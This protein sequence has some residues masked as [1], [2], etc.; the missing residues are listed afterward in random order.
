MRLEVQFATLFVVCLGL[1][2]L[3]AGGL[4]YRVESDHARHELEA[5]AELVLETATA[6][7]GY[8]REEIA[9]L[10]G[11][12]VDQVERPSLAS[13]AVARVLT[14]L[15]ERSRQFTYRQVSLDPIDPRNRAT[16]SEVAMIRRFL[17]NP[18]LRDVSGVQTKPEPEH[19]YMARPLYAQG[20]GCAAC[21]EQM[22]PASGDA[23]APHHSP[24]HLQWKSGD[25]VAAEIVEIPLRK[26]WKTSLT[27][28]VITSAGLAS[29]F[30][31]AGVVFLILFRRTIAV[32]LEAVTREAEQLS[33]EPLH[34][35]RPA[36]VLTGP[37]GRLA[38]AVRRLRISIRLCADAS[39]GKRPES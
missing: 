32:P 6:L 5:N 7:R 34:V 19:F 17:E 35:E 16:D 33:L 9:P 25:L 28:I 39:A 31:I 26:A 37:F 27:S 22:A 14:R 29:V 23:F 13:Y 10:V 24:Q 11:K 1:G 30:L 21:H 20:D 12:S 3:A 8:T 4:S 18:D 36:V 2:L 38:K 15:G